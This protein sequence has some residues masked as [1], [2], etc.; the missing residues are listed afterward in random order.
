M[1]RL[2]AAGACLTLRHIDPEVLSLEVG[3]DIKGLRDG[4]K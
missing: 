4:L 1:V 2:R 3:W